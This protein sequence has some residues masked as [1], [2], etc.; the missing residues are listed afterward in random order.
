MPRREPEFVRVLAPGVAESAIADDAT[1]LRVGQHVAP[2]RRRGLPG[3]DRDDVFTTV[4][5]K[6]AET[7]VVLHGDRFEYDRWRRLVHDL[8]GYVGLGHHLE[9]AAPHDLL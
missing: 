6:S 9:P 8:A 5:G 1:E 3:F 2:R 7:V 4:I